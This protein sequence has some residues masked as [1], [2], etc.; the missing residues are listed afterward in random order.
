MNQNKLG[1]LLILVIAL[2]IIAAYQSSHWGD[3]SSE[4]TRC[5]A[6]GNEVKQFGAV[7]YEDRQYWDKHC[8]A[9][10]LSGQ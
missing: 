7:S 1:V 2:V 10:S 4:T 5:I 6:I 8:R 9:Y 3:T